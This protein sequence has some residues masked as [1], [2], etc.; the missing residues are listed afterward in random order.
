MVDNG[1]ISTGLISGLVIIFGALKQ[2]LI[3]NPSIL[4][5]LMGNYYVAYVAIAIAILSAI[6]EIM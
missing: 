1:K 2:T 4:Q 6:Y 5:S 3:N